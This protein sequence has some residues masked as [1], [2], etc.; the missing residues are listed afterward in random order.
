MAIP[1]EQLTQQHFLLL[2]AG[3]GAAI[4]LVMDGRRQGYIPADDLPFV[5]RLGWSAA[6]LIAST[7]Y[8]SLVELG[9][10]ELV[11]VLAKWVFV[12]VFLTGI[13]GK[14]FNL[15]SITGGS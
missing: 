11:T 7:G 1:V 12:G 8:F 9:V 15:D 13:L 3:I 4:L 10:V 5:G 6:I 14:A 2:Y